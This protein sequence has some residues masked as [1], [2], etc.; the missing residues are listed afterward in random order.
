M[1]LASASVVWDLVRKFDSATIKKGGH[2][3]KKGGI[4]FTTEPLSLTNLHTFK[5]SGRAQAKAVGMTTKGKKIVLVIKN[6]AGKNK[7]GAV[8]KVTRESGVT[9]RRRLASSCFL[10]APL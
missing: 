5:D 4:K 9:V 6:K 3:L 2:S 10:R 8:R 1:S 7:K